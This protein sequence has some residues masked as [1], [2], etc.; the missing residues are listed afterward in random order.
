MVEEALWLEDVFLGLEWVLDIL[1]NLM[2][3]EDNMSLKWVLQY[4][5]DSR[6]LVKVSSQRVRVMS[7]PAQRPHLNSAKNF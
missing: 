2:L 1:E 5:N 6:H 7:W 4:D 3:A